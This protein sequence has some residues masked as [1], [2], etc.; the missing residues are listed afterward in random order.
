M[1][2]IDEIETLILMALDANH[3]LS[4]PG[5]LLR[6]KSKDG[7]ILSLHDQGELL[8]F[9]EMRPNSSYT[10]DLCDTER[11]FATTPD[12]LV[13]H[14]ADVLGDESEI[15]MLSGNVL[16]WHG[17]RRLRKSPKGVVYIGKPSHWYE[18]HGRLVL[19]NGAGEYYKRIIPIDKSGKPLP[20]MIQGH[21]VCA[22]SVEGVT[23][24]LGASTIEDAH[25]ANAMLASVKCSTEIKFPVPLDDY[26]E[27]FA[28]RDGPLN[29]SRRKSI[30]HWVSRHLRKSP[31]GNEFSVK[32]HTRGIQEFTIDGIQIR[33]APN[34]GLQKHVSN[35]AA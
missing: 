3:G 21:C 32:R 24:M 10:F 11:L 34:D 20:A 25:R 19:K 2:A 18:M 4:V 23:L 8:K 5:N 12:Y 33:I 6:E 16:K 9:D 15:M 17:F 26:K 30:L 13:A 35:V 7:G 27:V 22:P 31:R 28:E 29:G 1:S 14:P